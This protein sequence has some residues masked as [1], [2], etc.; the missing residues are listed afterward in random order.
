MP[1][2]ECEQGGI[3]QSAAINFFVATSNNLM[4]DSLFESAKCMELSEH[5]SELKRA[6]Y[7]HKKFNTPRTL[8]DNRKYK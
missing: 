8:A 4:G 7:L 3:G 2:L 1:N 5:L 6:W